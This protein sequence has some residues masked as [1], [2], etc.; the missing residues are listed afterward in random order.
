MN[1]KVIDEVA[2][3]QSIF[4]TLFETQSNKDN[5]ASG[6]QTNK[7]KMMISMEAGENS[8][9]PFCRDKIDFENFQDPT[10]GLLQLVEADPRMQSEISPNKSPLKINSSDL[11]SR[12]SMNSVESSDPDR[13]DVVKNMSIIVEEVQR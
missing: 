9:N 8:I 11:K 4:Y 6:G 10:N 13:L 12:R 5:A 1:L 2:A 7:Q 3:L